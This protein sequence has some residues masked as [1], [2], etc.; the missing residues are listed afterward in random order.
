MGDHIQTPI[1]EAVKKD[2]PARNIN[3]KYL[4][5]YWICHAGAQWNKMS[6]KCP[7]Y[8][9]CQC[10]LQKWTRASVLERVLWEIAKN[11]KDWGD[12]EMFH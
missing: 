4:M 2:R 6:N 3:V 1:F 12:Q 8:Q 7:P 11:L 9:I 5:A 10:Y